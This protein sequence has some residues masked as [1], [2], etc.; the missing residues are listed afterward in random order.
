MAARGLG[1]GFSALIPDD[2]IDP[3]FDP[4][5]EEDNANSKLAEIKLSDIV[6]DENQPRRRFSDDQL[7]SLAESIREHGVLQPIVVI[8]EGS[9][10]KIVA[11]ER[12]WRASKLAELKTI[13]AVVRSLDAQNRLELSLIENV[14][15]EDL[16]A[17]EVA[18]AYAKLKSQFNMSIDDV[19]KRVGKSK[20]SV[21]N[22][23][24]LLKLPEKAKTAML[25]YNLT[26][27]QMRPLVNATPEQLD[28]L[29]KGIIEEDWSA[30]KVE[31]KINEM[32][33]R[34]QALK[35]GRNQRPPMTAEAD[36][37]MQRMNRKLG[38]DVKV[39]ANA[40]G[41]GNI[42]IKFKNEEE[43]EK[44]CTILTK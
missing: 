40:R 28:A 5:N 2:L 8:K 24:R 17:I 11:G 25:E 38:V 26:E 27:G 39:R 36:K 42:V 37:Y 44:L 15:R 23:M 3:T 4:T 41:G 16:N 6:P 20:P 34:S 19:A 33:R 13:P 9:K 21:V 22:T 18:T 14:Q 35:E 29:L 12:R 1:R 7:Q 43:F 10:Y 30:R 32:R 31:A